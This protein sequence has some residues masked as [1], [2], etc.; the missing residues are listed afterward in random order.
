M[1]M[2]DVSTLSVCE[3]RC[4]IGTVSGADVT[5]RAVARCLNPNTATVC[6][7]MTEDTVYCFDDQNV[8]EAG[9]I[10]ADRQVRRL[11]V[12][13]RKRHLL[14]IISL[15]DLALCARK[16]KLAR[17]VL[18]FRRAWSRTGDGIFRSPIPT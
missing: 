10:M 8:H 15:A 6:E 2:L 7:V 9:R 16:T 14:G 3:D 18:A 17:E 4:L 13:N 11:P 12:V 1:K 5:F